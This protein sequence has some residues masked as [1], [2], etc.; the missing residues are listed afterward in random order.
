MRSVLD[1]LVRFFYPGACPACSAPS[2]RDH[3]CAECARQVPLASAVAVPEVLARF[4]TIVACRHAGVVRELILKLKFGRDPHPA[5]ALGALL[6]DVLVSSAFARDAD[7]IVPIPLSRS[8]ARRRGFNQADLIASA[9]GRRLGVPLLPGILRRPVHRPP[10]ADLGP[11][12]RG[13]NV[14]G[15]FRAGEGGFGRAVLLLDDVITTGH[16]MAEAANTI[17]AAGA[18]RVSCCAVAES[19]WP[20]R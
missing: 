13:R 2:D 5:T 6:G 4:P 12:E 15:V 14:R 7:A 20:S 3:L 17:L 16:T 19:G 9:V 11:T 18:R 10:Q 8:R 1:S